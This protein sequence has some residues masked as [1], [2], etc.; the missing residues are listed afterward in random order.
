MD[1]NEVFVKIEEDHISY[2]GTC[3]V[4]DLANHFDKLR[5]LLDPDSQPEI[6][7]PK[8]KGFLSLTK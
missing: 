2:G 1:I 5:K 3:K 7:Q 4:S 6:P 8:K